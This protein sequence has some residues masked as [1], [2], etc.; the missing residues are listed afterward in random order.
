[1]YNSYPSNGTARSQVGRS[2]SP[3]KL[4]G[5]DSS[6]H[7]GLQWCPHSHPSGPPRCA[8]PSLCW[9]HPDTPGVWGRAQRTSSMVTFQMCVKL[10]SRPYFSFRRGVTTAVSS[11]S[12][13]KKRQRNTSEKALGS[14][15]EPRVP[16]LVSAHG[17]ETNQTQHGQECVTPHP[18]GP[19]T[20]WPLPH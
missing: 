6:G 5:G 2:Q 8:P 15:T 7:P 9:E 14:T 19:R 16:V 20:A 4:M 13:W 11:V 12:A 3:G 10:L 17:E 18:F 1:M